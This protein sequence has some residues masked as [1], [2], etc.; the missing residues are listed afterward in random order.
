MLTVQ[1]GRHTIYRPNLKWEYAARGAA[2]AD[3]QPSSGFPVGEFLGSQPL[4]QLLAARWQGVAKRRGLERNGMKEIRR[5]G[6]R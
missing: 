1:V 3:G 6:F 5:Q 4:E 2:P